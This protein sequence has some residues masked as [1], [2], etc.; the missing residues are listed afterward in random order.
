MIWYQG[1][2]QLQNDGFLPAGGSVM[3]KFVGDP[4]PKMV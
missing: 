2:R 4:D 3:Q 1:R